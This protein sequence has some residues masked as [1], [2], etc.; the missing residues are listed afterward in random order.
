MS[1]KRILGRRRKVR[2]NKIQKRR[3]LDLRK[4]QEVDTH[5]MQGKIT[6]RNE[7]IIVMTRKLREKQNSFEG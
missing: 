7:E 6:W 5:F 2:R 3:F 4:V 1:R